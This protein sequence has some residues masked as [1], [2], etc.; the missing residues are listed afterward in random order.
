MDL[1]ISCRIAV[2]GHSFCH[3]CI[4]E[5]LV[6]KK[7]C[8]QCRKNIRRKVLQPSALID[9]S[10]KMVVQGKSDEGAP[11]ELAR[12]QER[13]SKYNEW[14]ESSVL[15]SV[16]V[17]EKV[18]ACDTEYIWCK[19]TVEMVIRTSNRKDLL[20]V[21]YEGWNRKY[22]EYVYID[23]HRLA[24]LGVYTGRRDIPV[25]RMMGNRGG[26]GQLSMMYAVVLSNAAEEA[27]IADYERRLTLQRQQAE[28]DEEDDDEDED[29]QPDDALIPD[30]PELPPAMS[31]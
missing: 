4:S 11:E 13:F 26:D 3:Q 7:E 30:E 20:Y 23:S 8:P 17:G 1:I 14:Q 28:E 31:V 12:W 29:G 27:R 24:P 19:A 21:H 5:C 10:V 22:D 6:R 9:N 15:K 25:Y 16:N 18:D 2:C